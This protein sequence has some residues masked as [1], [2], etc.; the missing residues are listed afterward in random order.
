MTRLCT[1]LLPALLLGACAAPTPPVTITFPLPGARVSN[2]VQVDASAPVT[3]RVDGQPAGTGRHWSGPL[4]P[5]PHT[6]TAQGPR[7]QASLTLTVLDDA[8]PG[9]IRTLTPDAQGAVHLSAGTFDLILGN[10]GPATVTTLATAQVSARPTAATWQAQLDARTRALLRTPQRPAGQ[11]RLTAQTTAPLERTF[12]VPNLQDAGVTPVPATLIYAGTHVAAYAESGTDLQAAAQVART[13]DERLLP[14]EQ[15][16]FGQVSDVDADGRV[17]LLFTPRLNAAQVA[18]GFFNPADLLARSADNPH[19]NEAELLYLG[20]PDAAD[21]NFTPASLTATACHEA[22]HLIHFA[23]KTLPRLAD[24]EP[25]IEDL[26]VSE[27]F[28]HLAEDLCGYGTLGGNVAFVARFLARGP[29]VSLDGTDLTGG[30][31]T[32][33]RRGAMYTFLRR[34]YE[35]QADPATWLRQVSTSSGVGLDNVARAGGARVDA[36]LSDWWWT[37]ALAG[38]DAPGARA[39]QP[40]GTDPDTGDTTGLN[41]TAGV[42]P[43]PGGLSVTLRGYPGSEAFPGALPG[44]GFAYRRVQGPVTLTVPRGLTLQVLGR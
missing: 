25:P 13:F 7:E 3:W 11:G 42:V 6:V 26:A 34:Q 21:F 16:L 44:R 17:L 9:E 24:A 8:P 23:H 29:Q 5:G 4:P 20:A 28:A 2:P 1:A 27:G 37:V 30:A 14:R 32:A 31:D 18:V 19:S 22:Q 10:P 36:L 33:E 43:L 39:Y 38:R 35:R 12:Q 41:L 40:T 15:R